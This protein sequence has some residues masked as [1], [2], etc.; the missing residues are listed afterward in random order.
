MRPQSESA[1]QISES[2][3]PVTETVISEEPIIPLATKILYTKDIANINPVFALHAEVPSGW[4]V[5]AVPEI[6]ALNLYDPTHS[7]SSSLEQSQIFL[8]FFRASQFLTLST[9][10]IHE[11]E[12]LILQNRPA[13]RYVIEKQVDVA[14]FSAQPSWRNSRHTV[15]DI[16]TTDTSPTTFYVVA[17]RPDLD[18][19]IYQT[20][21]SS[22]MIDDNSAETLTLPIDDF[23]A[24]ITKKPF[25]LFVTPANS[26]VSPERF[27]GYH[28]GVD[29]EYAD[30]SHEVPVQAMAAGE[31][32]LAR[33]ADG[34]GGVVAIR[35]ELKEGSVVAIYGHLDPGVLPLVG[36]RVEAGEVIGT[37]GDGGTDET[38]G[39]RKHL[40]FSVFR[41][42][43]INLRGYVATE[44]ELSDWIDPVIFYQTEGLL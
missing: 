28:T 17:A 2:T 5:E 10:T 25:G 26:P 37:L 29:I 14:D 35:H 42:N 44:A 36:G 7:A 30:V 13:V 1:P 31:I 3:Q 11:R 39:E 33:R 40:H 43:E 15:T 27:L 6:D 24:R 21:L 19:T 22:L 34:Y 4:A 8:R 38:D 41:G 16:R 12:E 9:V 20:F 18:P 23:V 32:V